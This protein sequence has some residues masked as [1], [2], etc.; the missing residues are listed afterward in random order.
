[1]LHRSQT[2]RDYNIINFSSTKYGVIDRPQ[3]QKLEPIRPKQTHSLRN[4][5]YN[6]INVFESK[7]KNKVPFENIVTEMRETKT[8]DPLVESKIT[9][10]TNQVKREKKT[11]FNAS[12]LDWD[13]ISFAKRGPETIKKI[14]AED[15]KA[16]YKVSP[17][18]E[19]GHIGRVTSP[20]FNPN[21]QAIVSTNQNAFRIRT[22]FGGKLCD[23]RKS[24]GD[25]AR[26]WKR[27]GK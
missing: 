24:Y 19:F 2:A 23:S 10:D 8:Y 18:S 11:L 9:Y 21:F 14:R 16:S 5:N 17:I 22:G 25:L 4:G 6:T 12:S 3:P 1:M 26:C 20:N 27:A 15:P 13:F 7:T